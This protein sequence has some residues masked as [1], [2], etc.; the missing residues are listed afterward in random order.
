MFKSKKEFKI[1][2]GNFVY[3][4]LIFEQK[5][6]KNMFLVIFSKMMIVVKI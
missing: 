5:V 6:A 1:N 4:Y 3:F 2:F